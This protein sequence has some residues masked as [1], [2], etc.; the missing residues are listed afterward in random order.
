MIGRQ[1]ILTNRSFTLEE[2]YSFME[3]HWDT[4]KYNQ[5]EL[6]NPSAN[7][8]KARYILLPATPRFLT[9]IYAAKAGGLFSKENKV[10]LSTAN[11]PSGMS[12]SFMRSIPS[13]SILFGAAKMGS[14]MSSEQE[15][16]GPAEEAL[17]AYTEYMRSLLDKAGYLKLASKN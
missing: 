16:K 4:E 17:L 5:F 7:F 15:R 2:L 3:E 1:V 14:L 11:T 10:V 12:E 13:S 8:G 6:G 9:F